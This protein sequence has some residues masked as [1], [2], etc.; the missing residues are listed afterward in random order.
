MT[1][2][3]DSALH[4]YLKT[5]ASEIA[6]KLSKQE[7]LDFLEVMAEQE[8]KRAELEKKLLE[9]CFVGRKVVI[10]QN[11]YLHIKDK[12]GVGVVATK[13]VRTIKMTLS[14]ESIYSQAEE[15]G[16]R[17]EEQFHGG[18]DVFIIET[19]YSEK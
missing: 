10:N 13:V 6:K 1:D 14:D 12:M 19:D 16:R 8:K 5:S 18:K 11:S 4:D 2:D 7:P 3:K 9:E 17:Y 15:F